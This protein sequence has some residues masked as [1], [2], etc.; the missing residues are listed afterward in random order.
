[1]LLPP[2]KNSTHFSLHDHFC[3]IDAPLVLAIFQIQ[4]HHPFVS[5]VTSVC[6]AKLCQCPEKLG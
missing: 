6:H 3:T 5:P 4:P 2:I 1:M